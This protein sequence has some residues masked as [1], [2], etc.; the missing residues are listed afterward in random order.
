M[1]DDLYI[2]QNNCCQAIIAIIMCFKFIFVEVI[3]IITI[4]IY[5][6][7]MKVELIITDFIIKNLYFIQK[8][9]IKE[10]FDSLM[11]IINYDY[12]IKEI[13]LYILMI[14]LLK[15]LLLVY[16]IINLRLRS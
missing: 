2:N 4:A 5:Y 6:A 9:T 13:K 16:I 3:N 7:N 10:C 15:L 12:K 8:S 14:R 1:K 11:I